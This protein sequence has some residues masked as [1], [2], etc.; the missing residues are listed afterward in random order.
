MLSPY[1]PQFPQQFFTPAVRSHLETMVTLYTDMAQRTLETLQS[2][3]E[4]N[5][6]L[7]RDLVAETG[8]NCQR[9]IASKDAGQLG[10]AFSAQLAPGATALQ[11]YQ[12][13][14]A[15]VLSRGSS[16]M[17]QTASTHMPAVRRTA[18]AVAEE[19]VHQA[20]EQTA[21][22]T[23]KMSQYQAASQVRH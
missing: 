16:S 5:L 17:A 10:A 2:L 3:S 13:G 23:E 22:A 8:A 4:L 1:T 6:Q 12:R 9:L 11:T 20:T 19:F 15:D 14:L 21:R 18:N 7:G